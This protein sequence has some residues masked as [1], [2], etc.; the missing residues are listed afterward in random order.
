MVGDGVGRSQSFH[1]IF[2]YVQTI[3][4]QI[5]IRGSD[6]AAGFPDLEECLSRDQ[7]FV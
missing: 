1:L 3:T 7:Q 2:L 4:M 5:I 6:V